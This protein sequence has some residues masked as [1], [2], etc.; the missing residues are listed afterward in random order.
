MSNIPSFIP[1][2]PI[3]MSDLSEN[4]QVIKNLG[5]FTGSAGQDVYLH[6]RKIEMRKSIYNWDA[7]KCMEIAKL[8][9]NGPALNHIISLAPTSY[10]ALKDCLIGKFGISKNSSINF[11]NLFN[12]N[13]GNMSVRDYINQLDEARVKIVHSSGT[14]AVDDGLMFAALIKGL[15]PKLKES[16]V[17]MDMSDYSRACSKAI[18]LETLYKDKNSSDPLNKNAVLPVKTDP[19]S[20]TQS[21]SKSCHFCLSTGH[22]IKNCP[23][24]LSQIPPPASNY[25]QHQMNYSNQNMRQQRPS[26]PNQFYAGQRPFRAN[27]QCYRCQKFGHVASNCYSRNFNPSFGPYMPANTNAPNNNRPF[28]QRNQTVWNPQFPPPSLNNPY[29]PA[30]LPTNPSKNV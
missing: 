7:S 4:E 27:V 16:L 17:M 28:M 8:T 22:L 21:T 14:T 10:S 6:F 9:L 26:F 25:A 18:E 20:K 5:I 19:S 2:T 13:Q 29:V 12:L 23:I 24:R 1:I 11:S 30:P 3:K 15:N